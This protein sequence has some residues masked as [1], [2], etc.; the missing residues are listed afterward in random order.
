MTFGIV[1]KYIYIRKTKYFHNEFKI[2]KETFPLYQ[3][4][5]AKLLDLLGGWKSC[6]FPHHVRIQSQ[7][8][9]SR[10]SRQGVPF[11]LAYRVGI[12]SFADYCQ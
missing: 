7:D 4:M 6:I 1:G 8:F 2:I 5:K 12:S 11:H 3:M 10:S 9:K